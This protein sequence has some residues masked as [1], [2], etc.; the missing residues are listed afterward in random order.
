[1]DEAQ[2]DVDQA[3]VKAF[4][5]VSTALEI[6]DTA[7]APA[8]IGGHLDLALCRMNLRGCRQQSMIWLSDYEVGQ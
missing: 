1:M 6:L 4:G 2:L 5:L 3:I 7:G 8:D